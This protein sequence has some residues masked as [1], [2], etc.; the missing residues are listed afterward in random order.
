MKIVIPFIYP[1]YL[2]CFS[3][4]NISF[5]L[6]ENNELYDK[7]QH[8]INTNEGDVITE[9]EIDSDNIEVVEN[10]SSPG[11]QP[12]MKEQFFNANSQPYIN[13]YQRQ[14]VRIGHR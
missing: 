9:I 3:L 12:L 5:G 7:L 2:A 11:V 1:F 10:R 8:P 4:F 13:N 6:S 14:H